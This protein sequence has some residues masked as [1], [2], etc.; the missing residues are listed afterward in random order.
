[1][2]SGNNNYAAES[3]GVSKRLSIKCG[4]ALDGYFNNA[5]SSVDIFSACG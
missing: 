3:P 5:V 1:M 4:E 2:V